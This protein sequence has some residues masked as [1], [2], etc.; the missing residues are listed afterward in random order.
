MRNL[1]LNELLEQVEAKTEVTE[2]AV[3]EMA[4]IGMALK[5]PM[6]NDVLQF[7]NN[8]KAGRDSVTAMPS[9]RKRDVQ[10]YVQRCLRQDS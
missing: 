1:S 8:L 7:W 3:N 5:F 10:A 9:S 6:A 4:I 2:V